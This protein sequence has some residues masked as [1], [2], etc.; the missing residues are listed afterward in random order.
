MDTFNSSPSFKTNETCKSHHEIHGDRTG[1]HYYTTD[2]E[3]VTYV[4]GSGDSSGRHAS[5]GL[6]ATRFSWRPPSSVS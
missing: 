1:R 6:H 3:P 5:Y 2:C 4:Y